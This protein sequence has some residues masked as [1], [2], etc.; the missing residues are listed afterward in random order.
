MK[1]ILAGTSAGV[2]MAGGL[3]VATASAP[4]QAD[5]YGPTLYTFC[6]ISG[7]STSA[8]QKVVFKLRVSSNSVSGW[9]PSMTVT[10]IHRNGG[11]NAIDSHTSS[12]AGT[13]TKTIS[14]KAKYR[15]PQTISVIAQPKAGSAYQ[16]CT[17]RFGL[18]V[19][20]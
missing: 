3:L 11:G 1:K 18:R 12:T 14:Y 16:G 20:K 19:A 2:L 13:G 9:S 5:P 10:I 6:D 7:V 15:G 8:G 17:A 4:A